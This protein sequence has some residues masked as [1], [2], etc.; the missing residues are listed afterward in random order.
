MAKPAMLCTPPPMHPFSFTHLHVSTPLQHLTA[1]YSIACAKRLT[2]LCPLPGFEDFHVKSSFR[3]YKVA[4]PSSENMYVLLRH[5]PKDQLD[6]VRQ[7]ARET[8]D[9]AGSHIQQTLFLNKIS[10]HHSSRT[11][12]DKKVCAEMDAYHPNAQSIRTAQSLYPLTQSSFKS[13]PSDH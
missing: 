1:F 10:L 9:P 11:T 3:Q 5:S 13:N 8:I 6:P 12:R 4:G 7:G 2:Y